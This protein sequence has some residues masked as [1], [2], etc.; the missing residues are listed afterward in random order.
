MLVW[1]RS[2]GS[3]AAFHLFFFFHA[4]I[5]PATTAAEFGSSMKRE[6]QT[7]S[8]FMIF[9]TLAY[10]NGLA[11]AWG[12]AGEVYRAFSRLDPQRGNRQ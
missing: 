3:D 8:V 11:H 2:S 4:F 5:M 1:I 6:G 12:V 9:D 10:Q 7:P